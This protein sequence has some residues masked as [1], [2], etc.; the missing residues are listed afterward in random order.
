[1]VPEDELY[2][3]QFSSET[4]LS[5][6]DTSE[7]YTNLAT[8]A[9]FTGNNPDLSRA[10]DDA[11]NDEISFT[12]EGKGEFCHTWEFYGEFLYMRARDVEV[13]YAVPFDG[14]IIPPANNPRVQV[15]RFG[16]L[17]MN[18]EPAF[19]AGFNKYLSDRT[20]ISA[21]YTLYEGRSFD[22][23]ITTAPFVVH[24][25]VSHPST[26]AAAQDFLQAVGRYDISMDIIDVDLRRIY[27]CDQGIELGWLLGIRTALHEQTMRVN[28]SG[29]GTET[30]ETDIDFRGVG[31]K[32]GIDGI[33][34]LG[35]C[36]QGYMELGGSFIPGVYVA[37]FTQSQSY[38][39]TVVATGW[40]AGRI[41]SIWDLE[42]GISRISN[43]GKCRLN[44]GYMFSAWTNTL[45]TDAWIDSVHT[46]NL[47]DRGT[48]TTLD[49]LVARCELRY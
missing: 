8:L 36:W 25:L 29:T 24:S 5:E 4:S 10:L 6:L 39:P 43:D 21:E 30:V 45:Q 22:S 14:P 37:D 13:T 49:G 7:S 42:V 32:F 34:A 16:V 41:V 35:E 38:D 12:Y 28:L 20:R 1:M 15:G 46:N 26:A 47:I 44:V 27:Y 3:F 9:E 19:R 11:F 18:Y 23:T 48:T 40:E 31:L 2:D 33:L 17:D